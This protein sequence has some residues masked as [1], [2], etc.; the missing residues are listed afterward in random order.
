MS[1]FRQ[2]LT[3][4]SDENIVQTIC[5]AL[6]TAKAGGEKSRIRLFSEYG[7]SVRSEAR[8]EMLRNR[9]SDAG[10][11]AAES[12]LRCCV[13]AL[14]RFPWRATRNNLPA[15]RCR[16]QIGKFADLAGAVASARLIVVMTTI[17]G[18]RPPA[19]KPSAA[20]LLCS[21]RGTQMKTRPACAPV[22]WG[23]ASTEA[24]TL[25]S[26][27]PPRAQ[28]KM[29][30]IRHV[31]RRPQQSVSTVPSDIRELSVCSK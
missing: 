28:R 5:L 29:W 26:G 10:F 9:K 16:N 3:T 14:L 22:A 20:M 24:W 21:Y 18:R 17:I 25:R 1:E 7:N 31:Q 19:P 6:G 11:A 12:L 30:V 8:T 27:Y 4:A 2:L 23:E 15:G 13:V